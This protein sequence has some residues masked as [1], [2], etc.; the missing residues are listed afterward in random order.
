M[1]SGYESIASDELKV[2]RRKAM[3][4]DSH[5]EAQAISR[6]APDD[7]EWK[8]LARE[9]KTIDAIKLFRHTSGHGLKESKDA[10]EAYLAAR[11]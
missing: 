1:D 8:K 4:W 6:D 3:L 10:V 9:G 7:S 5:E 2:L 11:R